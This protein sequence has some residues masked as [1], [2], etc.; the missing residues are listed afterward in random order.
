MKFATRKQKCYMHNRL[1]NPKS[2]PM[3]KITTKLKVI[4]SYS[5][6]FPKSENT[7]FSSG[8][9]IDVVIKIIPNFWCKIMA[10]TGAEPHEIDFEKLI[11][12]LEIP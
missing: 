8:E 6:R 2:I 5:K 4:N 12:N 10:Q 1:K 11:K 3:K 9:K 7:E